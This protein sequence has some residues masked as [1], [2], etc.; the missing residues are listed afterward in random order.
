M[1]S[2][3]EG[4][5]IPLPFPKGKDGRLDRDFVRR[6]A[7]AAWADSTEHN[8]FVRAVLLALEEIYGNS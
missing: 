3:S 5:S 8:E 1:T 4:R 2:P 6:V 7:S